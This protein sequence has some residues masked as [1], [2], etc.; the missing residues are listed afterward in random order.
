[1]TPSEPFPAPSVGHE[2]DYHLAL[3]GAVVWNRSDEG[4]ILVTGTDRLEWL[5]GLLSNDVARLPSGEGVYACY[6]TAQGRMISDMRLLELGDRLLIDVPSEMASPLVERLA[7]FV[8]TEDVTLTD[9]SPALARLSVHG[10]RAANALVTV[11]DE[12]LS[13]EQ[14]LPNANRPAVMEGVEVVLA[15]SRDLKLVGFDVYVPASEV[16]RVIQTLDRRGVSVARSST[17]EVLRI[18][19]GVPRFGVDMDTTTIP[20]E[21]GI[22]DEAISFTKGCY[23]G[24]EIVIRML[25]R[26][27]GRVAR[28]LAGI[29]VHSV[30]G[31][32]SQGHAH[33]LAGCVLLHQDREVG[34][35]TSAAW[36]PT[37]DRVIALGYLARDTAKV[38]QTILIRRADGRLDRGEVHELPLVPRGSAL[39]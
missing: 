8:I 19:G 14:L 16:A 10:P 29:V 24:Q 7:S 26:G 11:P 27:H 6:L 21:A 1:M 22:E 32:A 15:R 33:A 17:F 34:R 23:V 28:K 3:T 9:V 36:S 12:A 2:H 37:L 20:L 25:H 5:Q 4:R 30:E 31:T 39:G 18:E 38:G 35:I 13:L